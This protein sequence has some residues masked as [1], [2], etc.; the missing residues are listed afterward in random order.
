MARVDSRASIEKAQII[1]AIL[2]IADLA[3]ATIVATLQEFE[4]PASAAPALRILATSDAP[5]TPRD[6]AKR[7]DRDPSTATLVADK[8]EQAGLIARAPHPDDGR[9]R[10]LVLTERGRQLWS[11][12]R[13]R[14]HEPAIFEGTTAVDRRRLLDVLDRM[15]AA[16]SP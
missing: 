1:H 10:V 3:N 5:I 14:L 16:R 6:L 9:K 13:D 11:T 2:E 7:L 4:A 12:L 8:L 15:L